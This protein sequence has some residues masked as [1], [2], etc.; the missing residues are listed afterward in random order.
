MS[1]ASSAVSSRLSWRC[2]LAICCCSLRRC[3]HRSG[4][5][6]AVPGVLRDLGLADLAAGCGRESVGEQD[7][8]GNLLM[9]HPVS[10]ELPQLI[11]VEG[12][13]GLP[14]NDGA[15][16]FAVV[17]IGYADDTRLG[18]GGVLGDD[19]LD[20]GRVEVLAAADDDVLAAVHDA[21]PALAVE[22][23]DV[24]GAEPALGIDHY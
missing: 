2:W 4:G 24:T 11:G 3:R 14:A 15:R 13:A 5:L 23:A 10:H 16:F 6:Q 18:D 9:R 7:V 17:V 20:L 8:A 22:P 12:G 1:M 19:G 21:Q